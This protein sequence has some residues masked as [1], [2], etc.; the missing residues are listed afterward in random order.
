M[1]DC[2]RNGTH[3][4]GRKV[5]KEERIQLHDGD[6]IRLLGGWTTHTTQFRVK[7][8]SLPSVYQ[9]AIST[10]KHDRKNYSDNGNIQYYIVP[11]IYVPGGKDSVGLQEL[12]NS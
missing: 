4:N 1:E 11:E 7:L 2:S 12:M 9:A 6:V 3:I 5:E 8:I 10:V